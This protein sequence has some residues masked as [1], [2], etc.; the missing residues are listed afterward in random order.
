MDI[1]SIT[2]DSDTIDGV[3][4]PASQ[5]QPSQS[6][7]PIGES[8]DPGRIILDQTQDALSAPDRSNFMGLPDELLAA[9]FS[10]LDFSDRVNTS[11]VCAQWREVSLAYPSLL[12]S[13][14]RLHSH[15]D[16][17]LHQLF[18]RAGNAPLTLTA[19][20][21]DEHETHPLI[22]KKHMHQV[23]LLRLKIRGYMDEQYVASVIDALRTPAPLLQNLLIS[24][25]YSA[26]DNSSGEPWLRTAPALRMLKT[27]ANIVPPIWPQTLINLEHL[28]LR[29]SRTIAHTV[30]EFILFC[31]NLRTLGLEIELERWPSAP[32]RLPPTLQGLVITAVAANIDTIYVLSQLDMTNCPLTHI[33]ISL[34]EP[35]LTSRAHS[36]AITRWMFIKQHEA[37]STLIRDPITTLMVDSSNYSNQSLLEATTRSGR[38]IDALDVEM[39]FHIADAEIAFSHLTYL[40]VSVCEW[41]AVW[42]SDSSSVETSPAERRRWPAALVLE[43]LTMRLVL[44]RYL[45]EEFI[46]HDIFLYPNPCNTEAGEARLSGLRCPKL[47]KLIISTRRY[48]DPEMMGFNLTIAPETIREFVQAQLHPGPQHYSSDPSQPY[49]RGEKGR[50]FT[51]CLNGMHLLSNNIKEV[52]Q[53]L[54]MFDIIDFGPGHPAAEESALQHLLQW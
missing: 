50:A 42:V 3:S 43:E 2:C 10:Y 32:L 16:N 17:I 34:N 37:G 40:S 5:P 41:G 15:S 9:V 48:T 6:A 47:R 29:V 33:C 35:V 22:L 4:F 44:P 8:N 52:A 18:A 19:R 28:L 30:P 26:L 53:L 38:Q 14:I 23:R 24:D 25:F 36:R 39:Y 20:L 46:Q 49:G 27:Y 31:S 45:K 13:D 54:G 7:T 21:R 1:D 51:L 11:H 12:W